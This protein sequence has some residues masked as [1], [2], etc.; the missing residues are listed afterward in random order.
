MSDMLKEKFEEFVTES[1]LV[2]E[3]GD[4][5]P[6]VSAAVIPGGGGYEALSQSK[7]EVNSKA[8]AGE[9]KGTVGTDAVNG[10]GANSQS[11]TMVVHAQTET[12]KAK[13]TLV[14]KQLPLLALKAH[15]AMA[16]HRLLTSTILVI[17][18]RLKLLVLTQH[19]LPA[20]VL[21]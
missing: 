19:M 5:M 4:P 14:L 17:R 13:T 20:L 12:T 11:P 15:R 1:G 8:G 7:T 9:G 21:M 3:A 2:V 6:T 10:Y 16:L 18:A